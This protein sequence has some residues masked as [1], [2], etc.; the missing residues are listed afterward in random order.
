M[1]YHAV[2][3]NFKRKS[4]TQLW[5]L[6][7]LLYKH[8]PSE[9]FRILQNPSE[10]IVSQGLNPKYTNFESSPLATEVSRYELN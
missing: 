4:Q 1:Q 9:S 7:H 6:F 3:K 10:F 8:N 5:V 2:G